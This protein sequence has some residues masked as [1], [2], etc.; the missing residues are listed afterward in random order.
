M[1]YSVLTEPPPGFSPKVVVVACYC[2]YDDKILL[3]KRHP[4]SSQGGTWGVPAGKVEKGESLRQAVIREVFEEVGLD[5][6]R[7]DLEYLDRLFIRTEIT[8]YLYEMFK[9][10]FDEKPSIQLS[11]REHTEYLFV[12][13]EEA[14]KLPL[15]T[16]G[17]EAL[18][19]YDSIKDY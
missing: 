14:L 16:G 7:E 10:S 12:T 6:D 17:V 18:K 11:L 2:E 19:Y 8:E 4:D 15:I 1:E 9:I 5:I 3:L 13:T